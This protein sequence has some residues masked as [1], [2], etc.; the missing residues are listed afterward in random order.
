MANLG[1]RAEPCE[2]MDLGVSKPLRVLWSSLELFGGFRWFGTLSNG[3]NDF[4]MVWMTSNAALE[5]IG[6]SFR[7]ALC[8]HS[9]KVHK[10][11]EWFE[12]SSGWFTYALAVWSCWTTDRSGCLCR[13]H[14]WRALETSRWWTAGDFWFGTMFYYLVW[15]ACDSYPIPRSLRLCSWTKCSDQVH[16]QRV[17][18]LQI[19]R[20]RRLPF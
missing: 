4:Q 7:R 2:T 18:S 14:F 17:R 6:D 3:L 16:S 5:G 15:R 9:Q 20:F 19:L 1:L 12:N 11:F 13:S 8:C 10:H